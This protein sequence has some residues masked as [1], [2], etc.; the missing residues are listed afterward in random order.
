LRPAASLIVFTVL[1]GLGLGLIA[2]LGVGLGPDRAAFVLAA[3]LLALGLGGL[4]SAGHLARPDRAWRAFGEWR[5]SLL[6]REA[7]L[8]I[9]TLGLFALHAGLWA[10][11]GLPLVVLGWL[12]AGLALGTVHCTATIYAQLRSVPRWSVAPTPALFLVLALAGGLLAHQA[13]AGL[14]AGARHGALTLGLLVLAAGVAVRWQ[15]A[16]GARLWVQGPR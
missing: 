2:W 13:V 6:S 5:S 8:M 15:S 9:A 3:P 7:C 12:V 10:G 11:A 1:S 14:T 4:A 16:A